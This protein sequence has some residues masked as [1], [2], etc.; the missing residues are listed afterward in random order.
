MQTNM[1]D[2]SLRLEW[3]TICGLAVKARV[4]NLSFN[5]VIVKALEQEVRRQQL[6]P[7]T[8]SKRR[9]NKPPGVRGEEAC[10]RRRHRPPIPVDH[11]ARQLRK[12]PDL[13]ESPDQLHAL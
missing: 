5:D 8:K 1:V 2:Q 7:T 11:P 9:R 13:R 12:W 3:T 4:H 10:L 6:A